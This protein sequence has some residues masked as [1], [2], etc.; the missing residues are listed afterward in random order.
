MVGSVSLADSDKLLAS[1]YAMF[2]LYRGART[3]KNLES[4]VDPTELLV[5]GIFLS[6]FVEPFAIDP[7]RMGYKVF[8]NDKSDF[9]YTGQPDYESTNKGLVTQLLEKANNNSTLVLSKPDGS[10]VIFADL[11]EDND[12]VLKLSSTTGGNEHTIFNNRNSLCAT[13]VLISVARGRDYLSQHYDQVYDAE[14]T[15]DG[16]GNIVFANGQMQGGVVVPACLNPYIFSEDG[17]K[18]MFVNS[19]YLAN[20]SLSLG[21][22]QR[23]IP[24]TYSVQRGNNNNTLISTAL[25]KSGYT[26]DTLYDF[27]GNVAYMDVALYHASKLEKKRLLNSTYSPVPWTFM[28]FSGDFCSIGLVS[29]SSGMPTVLN[30][31]FDSE[32]ETSQIS[33]PLDYLM[34]LILLGKLDV[35]NRETLENDM[36]TIRDGLSTDSSKYQFVINFDDYLGNIDHAERDTWIQRV[37]N[38]KYTSFGEGL[39]TK[40]SIARQATFEQDDLLSNIA[41]FNKDSGGSEILPLLIQGNDGRDFVEQAYNELREN[42]KFLEEVFQEVYDSHDVSQEI[43]DSYDLGFFYGHIIPRYYYRCLALTDDRLITQ[44]RTDDGLI[45]T[46]DK[47]VLNHMYFTYLK[48]YFGDDSGKT[49]LSEGRTFKGVEGF[50]RNIMHLLT[51]A[52]NYKDIASEIIANRDVASAQEDTEYIKQSLLKRINGLLD[53]DDGS[54]RVAMMESTAKNFFSRQHYKM[55]NASRESQNATH[56]VNTGQSGLNSFI[57]TPYLGELN[58]FNNILTNYGVYFI[59]M[60]F[61]VTVFAI[62]F[63]LIGKVEFKKMLVIYFTILV[64]ILLPPYIVDNVVKYTNGVSESLFSEKFEIW[65]LTH[66]QEYLQNMADASTR[67]QELS[68]DNWEMA[69]NAS[70][71]TGVWI[72]WNSPKK[73]NQYKQLY[74]I[75]FGEDRVIGLNIFKWLAGGMLLQEFYPTNDSYYVYRSY[76]GITNTAKDAF[77]NAS[78]RTNI[79]TEYTATFDYARDDYD[80]PNKYVYKQL[81]RTGADVPEYAPNFE[82]GSSYLRHMKGNLLNKSSSLSTNQFSILDIANTVQLDSTELNPDAFSQVNGGLTSVVDVDNIYNNV[83][84]ERNPNE[85]F[86]NNTEGLYFYFY[87]VLRDYYKTVNTRYEDADEIAQGFSNDLLYDDLFRV[88]DVN[89]PS[90]MELKDFLDMENLFTNVIPQA[91]VLN[92]IAMQGVDMVNNTLDLNPDLEGNTELRD[93]MHLQFWSIYTPWVSVLYRTDY[94][95]DNNIGITNAPAIVQDAF[96][97]ECYEEYRPMLFSPAQQQSLGYSSMPLSMVE[98]KI[99]KVLE[100]TYND[101]RKTI[102]HLVFSDEALISTVA[103]KATFNF[104]RE[105]SQTFVM[106]ENAE[107]FPQAYNIRGFSYDVFMKMFLSTAT[108]EPLVASDDFYSRITEGSII[109]GVFLLLIDFICVYVVP[110]MKIIF[111]I[112]L[113]IGLYLNALKVI[114]TVDAPLKELVSTLLKTCVYPVLAYT[115]TSATMAFILSKMVGSSYMNLVGN[116]QPIVLAS[117]MTALL[118]IGV[119]CIVYMLLLFVILKYFVSTGI[120]LAVQTVSAGKTM[121]KWLLG[122]AMATTVGALS[123]ISYIPKR[124]TERRRGKFMDKQLEVLKKIDK[125]LEAGEKADK[126]QQDSHNL[127]DTTLSEPV[128]SPSRGENRGSGVDLQPKEIKIREEKVRDELD[129]YNRTNGGNKTNSSSRQQKADKEQQESAT[130]DNQ[131]TTTKDIQLDAKSLKSKT[132]KG[133]P[134]TDDISTFLQERKRD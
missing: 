89:S 53:P 6:N 47:A 60:T 104:N 83:S 86:L 102:N 4:D 75:K 108:G 96:D 40:L 64:L 43:Y 123:G 117:T 12:L 119:V 63:I 27:T 10:G 125:Q 105:F 127:D 133:M 114:F 48:Y 126:A 73:V 80:L 93:N 51:D 3:L 76:S 103:L 55:T 7:N 130:K 9:L 74:S 121:G 69:R 14:L 54:F 99:H 120:N 128:S 107:L 33:F 16:F 22:D 65:A 71:P 118:T 85:L 68:L 110:L 28:K 92:N 84:Q 32:S 30:R 45:K 129:S 87:N 20:Y 122:G 88:T 100:D 79:W 72:K 23:N 42:Y 39:Q 61:I 59:I 57:T 90:Y 134:V 49:E 66:H 52:G 82:N 1:E 37:I 111:I 15:V 34:R 131:P 116:S 115:I 81:P 2:D 97:P 77:E 8:L 29:T 98:R 19:Y 106:K 36:K 5:F 35:P 132:S 56:M 62:I 95:R 31:V 17:N 11:I 50:N 109:T 44:F 67:T 13:A 41:Q 91:R 113:F 38:G 58:V 94:W 46:M 26:G 18:L 21:A 101:C 25:S 124:L 70:D 24:Y 78:D 112:L